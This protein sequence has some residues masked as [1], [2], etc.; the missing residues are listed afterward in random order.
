[1]NSGLPEG[2]VRLPGGELA[3]TPKYLQQVIA[4]EKARSLAIPFERALLQLA[5]LRLHTAMEYPSHFDKERRQQIVMELP[6]YIHFLQEL[7]TAMQVAPPAG[8]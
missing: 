2:V 7:C 4:E 6:G 1:M 3:V 8:E 5:E